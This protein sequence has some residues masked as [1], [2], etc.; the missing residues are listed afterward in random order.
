[1]EKLLLVAV[2]AAAAPVWLGPVDAVLGVSDGPV[3]GAVVGQAPVNVCEFR[4]I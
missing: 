1:L 4:I 2:D 3:V